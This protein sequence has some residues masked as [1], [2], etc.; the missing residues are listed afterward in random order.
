[1]ETELVELTGCVTGVQTQD[2]A[3]NESARPRTQTIDRMY[4]IVDE[5]PAPN[6]ATPIRPVTPQQAPVPTLAH[7]RPLLL[8]RLFAAVQK[9][10]RRVWNPK[11]LGE[12]A[13]LLF[14]YEAARRG[15]IVSKPFGDSA[16]YDAVVESRCEPGK[17]WRVQVRSTSVETNGAYIIRTTFGRFGNRRLSKRHVDFIAACI[18]PHR[19]WYLIPVAAFGLKGAVCL[20]PHNKPKG[21]FAYYERFREAWDLLGSDAARAEKRWSASE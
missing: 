12:R 4:G 10:W 19:T 15:L 11:L 8:D 5:L 16:P 21:G 20:H 18:T 13:E 9:T 6:A 14:M 3:G 1:M 2:Q 17:L 7:S